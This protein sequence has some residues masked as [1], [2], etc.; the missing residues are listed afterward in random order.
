MSGSRDVA[1]GASAPLGA[2]VLPGGVNFSVFSK[3]AV[4]LELLLFDDENATEPARIIPL[5]RINIAPITTG[6]PS[7]RVFGRAR[8]TPTARTDLRSGPWASVRCREGAPRPLRACRRRPRDVRPLGRGAARRQC[9]GGD[10]KRRRRSRSVRLGRR[11]A[12]RAAVCR[13]RDLRAACARLHA[14]SQLG[15]RDREARDL[16]GTDR[17]DSLPQGSGRHRGRAAAGVP[18][19]RAGLPA[20]QRELLGLCSR[21][22]SSRHIRRTARRRT[23][24]GPRRISGHGEGASPRG[25]RSYPRCR[26]QSHG[27][28]RRR[29]GRRFAIA[30]WRTTSIT[31]SRGTSPVMPTTPAA[32]TR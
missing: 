10:E 16:C 25:P 32:A 30:V 12:A 28:R 5:V 23:P 18:V 22:R 19:R 2:T 3:H 26:V 29:P 31:S 8:C 20:G 6:M 11:S 14:P 17:E 24:R 1:P 9:R 7:C 27:G 4:L 13:D 21:F 15:C